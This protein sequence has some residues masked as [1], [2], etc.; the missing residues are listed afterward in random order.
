MQSNLIH[1]DYL[2]SFNIDICHLEQCVSERISMNRTL[3]NK[4][5]YKMLQIQKVLL[6]EESSKPEFSEL[7]AV[8]PDK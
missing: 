2:I 3:M 7:L 6:E 1:Y 4:Y 8:H 5:R